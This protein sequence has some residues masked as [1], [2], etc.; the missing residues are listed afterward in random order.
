[1]N[2][3]LKFITNSPSNTRLFDKVLVLVFLK[4]KTTFNGNTDASLFIQQLGYR[5]DIFSILNEVSICLQGPEF[6]LILYRGEKITRLNLFP[7]K[8]V[9]ECP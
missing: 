4:N 7:S 5:A 1:M 2:S 3:K 6:G 9:A 8:M